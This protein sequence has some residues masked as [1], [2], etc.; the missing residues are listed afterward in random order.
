M[1]RRIREIQMG[2]F[3]LRMGCLACPETIGAALSLYTWVVGGVSLALGV[4][5]G[6]LIF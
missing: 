3:A 5:V 6:G 2:L 4:I 1:K